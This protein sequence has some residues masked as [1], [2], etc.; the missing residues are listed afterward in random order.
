MS[1]T[2]HSNYVRWMGVDLVQGY[3]TA[4]P[5]KEMIQSIL[6]RTAETIRKYAALKFRSVG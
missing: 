5:E 6:S 4:R 2:H 1:I 3:F